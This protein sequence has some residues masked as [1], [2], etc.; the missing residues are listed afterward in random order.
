MATDDLT[1]EER[2]AVVAYLQAGLAEEKF[3]M[4]PGPIPIR[5]AL[6]KISGE[7]PPAPPKPRLPL[8]AVPRVVGA[9]GGESVRYPSRTVGFVSRGVIWVES[10]TLFYHIDLINEVAE[11]EG[12]EPSIRFPVYTLSR[13]APSTTRPPLRAAA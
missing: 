11:G 9:G 10:K 13:R 7:A 1:D 2:A 8:P 3:P 6:A 5:S 12:F 4:R